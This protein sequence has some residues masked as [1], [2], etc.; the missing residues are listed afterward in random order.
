MSAIKGCLAL[1]KE[2]FETYQNPALTAEI[3]MKDEE[4][5]MNEGKESGNHQMEEEEMVKKS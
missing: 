3:E 1:L 5:I 2:L 4:V